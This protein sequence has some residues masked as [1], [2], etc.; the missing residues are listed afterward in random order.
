MSSSLYHHG[1]KGMHWGV[2]RYQNSDG[3]LTEA[4]KKRY[5]S[6][7]R[8][9]LEKERHDYANE[10]SDKYLS[11]L[12]EG[13]KKKLEDYQEYRKNISDFAET[14]MKETGI[15]R[16]NVTELMDR[17]KEGFAEQLANDAAKA[18]YKYANEK[19][20][21][22]YWDTIIDDM[23]NDAKWRE[24]IKQGAAAASYLLLVL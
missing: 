19:M 9:A 10:G 18:G 17:E 4:G 13:T 14:V 20:K 11:N 3:T 12:D 8:K 6:K 22:K 1:I 24:R 15:K 2:R 7:N 5:V 23:N 21:T 16:L